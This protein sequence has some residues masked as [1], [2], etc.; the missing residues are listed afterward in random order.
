[1]NSDENMATFSARSP[2]ITKSALAGSTMVL[3]MRASRKPPN[4]SPRATV[5]RGSQ[6]PAT[7]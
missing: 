6:G 7:V 2:K 5:E 3:P 4:T 1:M